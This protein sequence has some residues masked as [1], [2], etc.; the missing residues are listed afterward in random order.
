MVV[1]GQRGYRVMRTT[2]AVMAA[3]TRL[4]TATKWIVRGRPRCMFEKLDLKD[5]I[6]GWTL[7]RRG[8]VARYLGRHG[9]SGVSK[10]VLISAVSAA[11]A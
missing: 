2:G 7:D 5:A 1:L 6:M 10:A 4:G 3:P 9:T 8:E 11:H